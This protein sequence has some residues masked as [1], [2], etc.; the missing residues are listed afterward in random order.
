LFW[1]RLI[2]LEEVVVVGYGTQK[3]GEMTGSIA[4]ASGE[5]L[6]KKNCHEPYYDASRTT[7]YLPLLFI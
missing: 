4:I 7:S 1:F 5:L 2:A 3:K 6:N